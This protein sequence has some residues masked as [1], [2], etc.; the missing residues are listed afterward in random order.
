MSASSQSLS[1]G[2][3]R[4]RFNMIEQQVRP[5]D[6]LDPRVLDLLGR[7]PREAFVSAA[8][9]ALAFADLD[10]PLGAAPDQV[11]LAPRL[12]ARLVQDLQLQPNDRVLEIGTGSGYTA[13]LMAH[14]ARQ[15]LTLEID[16]ALAQ[17]ARERLQAQGLGTQVT[18]R[19]A[20]ACA[21]DFA[22]CR[23]E[24][25]WDAILIGGSV[26]EVPSALLE[27]LAPGG[28][29][30][31]ITGHDPIMRATLITRMGE[32]SVF[33]TRQPWDTLAPRLR[34]F[35]EPSRFRF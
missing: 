17:A 34:H 27:L 35:P 1:A 16:P 32:A 31:A 29:L 21:E 2:F 12:Q 18:V 28:R 14:L 8:H 26:A 25:P 20:D 10:L 5:W 9:A 19:C 15:V 11:M 22:A 23:T 7:V 4:A 33:Q 30:I 24:A 3:E 13:A 6:V